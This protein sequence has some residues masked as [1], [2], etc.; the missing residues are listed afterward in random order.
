MDQINSQ[1][2]SV[3]I[4]ILIGI[5]LFAA[6]SYAVSSGSRNSTT[7][8][9]GEQAKLAAQEIIDYGNTVANAVQKLRLRGCGDAEISFENSQSTDDY[10]NANAPNDNTCHVFNQNGGNVSYNY[11]SET[12]INSSFNTIAAYNEYR[13][14]EVAINEVG[15]IE[16]ELIIQPVNLKKAVC[17]EINN[18]LGVDNPSNSPPLEDHTGAAF[19][20]GTYSA[21]T[22]DNIGD[23]GGHDISGKNAFCREHAGNNK[24]LQVLIAR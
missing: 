18:I 6:L 3:F 1:R 8:L 23:D 20:T 12:A 13:F 9:T 22:P 16:N 14:R 7:A 4:Y 10:T 19:F 11:I 17:I 2:G 21:A 15:T 24:Y 5:A